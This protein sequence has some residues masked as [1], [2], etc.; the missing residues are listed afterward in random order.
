MRISH[1]YYLY[2]F[3]IY[4][5]EIDYQNYAAHSQTNDELC[6]GK[7]WILHYE[8]RQ[9]Q[10]QRKKTLQEQHSIDIQIKFILNKIDWAN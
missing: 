3:N 8:I 2:V 1:L 10:T 7:K 5:V 6:I 4:I 9:K